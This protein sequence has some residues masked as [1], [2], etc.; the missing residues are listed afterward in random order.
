MLFHTMGV[1]V[2]V[3]VPACIFVAWLV[4]EFRWRRSLRIGLGI[5]WT[6]ILFLWIFTVVSA[7][8]STLLFHRT[9]LWRINRL[10]GDGRET[11]VRD[12][13]TV[14]DEAYEQTGSARQAALKMNWVLTEVV[15]SNG[16]KEKKG[17]RRLPQE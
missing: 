14:Y 17:E 13:L 5:A 15:N 3:L 1:V 2:Y 4:A 9:G 10:L 12:A 8:D 7:T 11:E 16:G 6:L